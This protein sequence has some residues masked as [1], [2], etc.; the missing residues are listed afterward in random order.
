MNP[1]GVIEAAQERLHA[2]KRHRTGTALAQHEAA[3]QTAVRAVMGPSAPL[4]LLLPPDDEDDDLL[5]PEA[6]AETP[7]SDRPRYVPTVPLSNVTVAPMLPDGEDTVEAAFWAPK[8]A[9]AEATRKA[10]ALGVQVTAREMSRDEAFRFL[11]GR[12][13]E[14]ARD[15]M[16]SDD[17]RNALADAGLIAHAYARVQIVYPK[18]AWTVIGVA[19]QIPPDLSGDGVPGAIVANAPGI[20]PP[21]WN[22][23]NIAALDFAR[24]DKCGVRHARKTVYVVESQ[25]TGDVMQV[26][27]T[28]AENLNAGKQVKRWMRA[29]ASI[30]SWARNQEWSEE[31]GM[32]G[33]HR[34]ASDTVDVDGFIAV[35]DWVLANTAWVSGREAY[36]TG[37]LSTKEFAVTL[38][39]SASRF[40]DRGLLHNVFGV[41]SLADEQI[42]NIVDQSRESGRLAWLR[43]RLD[44]WMQNMPDWLD[45]AG[46][47]NAIIGYRTGYKR[48]LGLLAYAIKD[49][50]SAGSVVRL[51]P[52]GHTY[53]TEEP[54]D[55]GYSVDGAGAARAMERGMWPDAAT[56]GAALGLKPGQMERALAKPGTLLTKAVAGK[57][58][59]HPA[60]V[61]QV[62]RTSVFEGQF[63]VS[64]KAVIM[65]VDDRALLRVTGSGAK[66]LD[67]GDRVRLG[68]V[69]FKDIDRAWTWKRHDLR[70][71]P[72]QRV[73][74][75]TVIVDND[76][77]GL[78]PPSPPVPVLAVEA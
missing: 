44:A 48:A 54:L 72:M 58:Q 1:D 63:G 27:G 20:E 6:P 8:G 26:G 31:A 16:R 71:P 13:V 23:Q 78:T 32:M 45:D 47:S 5:P 14:A 11:F 74:R 50:R 70:V 53:N 76:L 19:E 24:C 62:L 75:A 69:G 46:K 41:M 17:F 64:Y 59:K 67:A 12:S 43:S 15:N 38:L 34:R 4:D 28:C 30:L 18:S 25:R 35:V 55:L 21:Y 52:D 36:A 22:V 51:L 60:G 39:E 40:A 65:R 37:A 73:T 10:E 57:I 77:P 2:S 9:V 7:A 66:G 29:V 68:T 61:W 49:V 42:Q 33:G 3:Y 56:F